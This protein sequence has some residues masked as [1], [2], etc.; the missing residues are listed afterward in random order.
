MNDHND[1]RHGWTH[2]GTGIMVNGN[3]QPNN[4][5]PLTCNN[6]PQG[7]DTWSDMV[8]G[9]PSNESNMELHGLGIKSNNGNNQQ[10]EGWSQSA[11][12]KGNGNGEFNSGNNQP[13]DSEGM[14]AWSGKAPW[15]PFL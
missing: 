4:Q 14:E 3:N 8:N 7:T 10:N 1:E 9:N 2:G 6:Q 11:M 12:V 15:S 13:K 5:T